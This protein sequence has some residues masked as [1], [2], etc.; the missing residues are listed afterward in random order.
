MPL[1]WAVEAR[2]TILPRLSSTAFAENKLLGD[3]AMNHPNAAA[4]PSYL[5]CCGEVVDDGGKGWTGTLDERASCTRK[6]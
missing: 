3:A 1:V 2:S 6:R 4:V 5:G